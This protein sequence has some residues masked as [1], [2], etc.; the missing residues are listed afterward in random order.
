MVPVELFD[1][2]DQLAVRFLAHH[3]LAQGVGGDQHGVGAGGDRPRLHADAG[4]ERA[5]K[6]LDHGALRWRWRRFG[7]LGP[8]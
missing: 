2:A 3:N 8:E 4:L 1:A 5:I 6:A 7:W